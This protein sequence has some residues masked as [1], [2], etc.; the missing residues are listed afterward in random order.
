MR[1]SLDVADNNARVHLTLGFEHCKAF[2]ESI[3]GYSG[4]AKQFSSVVGSGSDADVAGPWVLQRLFPEALQN[5]AQFP[6]RLLDSTLSFMND[7]PLIFGDGC[8]GR[9]KKFFLRKDS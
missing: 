1:E 7:L 5:Q 3:F 6:L 8:L 2:L 4:C 9:P